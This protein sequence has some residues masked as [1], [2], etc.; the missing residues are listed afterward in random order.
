MQRNKSAFTLVEL[1]VVIGI[2]AILIGILLPALQKARDQANTVTCQANLR[3]LYGLIVAY[4]DDYRQ[5]VLPARMST[6]TQEYY[7]SDPNLLGNELGHSDVTGAL[8]AKNEAFVTRILT[9]P[10]ADHSLDWMGTGSYTGDYTYNGNMGVIQIANNGL[11]QITGSP[12]E[13]VSEVPNNVLLMTDTIKAYCW[14]NGGQQWRD[15]MFGTISYLLGYQNVPW[16][17][18]AGNC[19]DM[20]F[21]HTK[22]TQANCLFMDGHIALVRPDDFLIEPNGGNINI[23]LT[24]SKTNPPE[25][26]YTNSTSPSLS[27]PN[28]KAWLVGAYNT[29]TPPKTPPFWSTPWD[30]T[31]PTLY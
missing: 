25:W 1:L 30:K 6:P 14:A 15:Q 26:T 13:K 17:T 21:P 12:F 31:K 4:E 22:S 9:C 27:T 5:Y 11:V 10:S 29:G 7:W 2:I 23:N 18:G 16:N 20:W 3:Q 8:R 24:Q 19:P 28:V